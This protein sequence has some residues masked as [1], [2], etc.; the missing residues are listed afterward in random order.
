MA[1]MTFRCLQSRKESPYLSRAVLW[2]FVVVVISLGSIFLGI[3]V[4]SLQTENSKYDSALFNLLSQVVL[5]LLASYCTLMP[6][7][8]DNLKYKV[9][10]VNHYVFYF[11][12]A[13]SVLTAIVTPLSYAYAKDRPEVS[14]ILNF[15]SSLFSIVTATQLAGG[16]MQ[17]NRSRFGTKA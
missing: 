14:V 11:S 13:I 1:G 16:I 7:L 12:V 2:C 3:S 15:V 17:L 6:I 5:Q 8:D 9:V 10:D 4:A